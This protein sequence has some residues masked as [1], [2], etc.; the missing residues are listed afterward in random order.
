HHVALR[1]R[2]RDAH[3]PVRLGGI[4]IDDLRAV[5]PVVATEP[6]VAVVLTTILTADGRTA[7]LEAGRRIEE[8][9]LVCRDHLLSQA[10]ER[11]D[12]DYPDRTAMRR[13]DQLAV[14]WMDL[15]VRYRRGRE[16]VLPAP[17]ALAL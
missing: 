3:L 16:A 15:Q 14:S 12:V 4:V 1:I 13:H 5:R 2:D 6:G 11:C 10:L 17:P 8:H 7:E 9:R